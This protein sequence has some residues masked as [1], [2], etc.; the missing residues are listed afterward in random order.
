[1]EETSRNSEGEKDKREGLT[2]DLAG[3]GES[4][5]LRPELGC[6]GPAKVA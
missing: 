1:M 4:S 6:T 2:G 3:G 5:G